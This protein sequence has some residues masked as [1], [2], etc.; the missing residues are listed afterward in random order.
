[1]NEER[2]WQDMQHARGHMRNSRKKILGRSVTAQK[3][4]KEKEV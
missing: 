2:D 4:E 1:M 3:R